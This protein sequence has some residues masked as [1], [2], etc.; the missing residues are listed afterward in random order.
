MDDADDTNMEERPAVDP[1][2]SPVHF[3]KGGKI[4]T[5]DDLSFAYGAF[6]PDWSVSGFFSLM[7]PYFDAI[8]VIFGF[9]FVMS[10]WFDVM[11]VFIFYVTFK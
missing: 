7:N 2:V 6:Y 9:L 3:D 10:L 5:I 11:M 4:K 1:A 8:L